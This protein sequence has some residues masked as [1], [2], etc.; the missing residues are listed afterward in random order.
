MARII[1]MQ[2]GHKLEIAEFCHGSAAS[3]AAKSQ[4]KL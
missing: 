1:L 4:V 3:S 2:V